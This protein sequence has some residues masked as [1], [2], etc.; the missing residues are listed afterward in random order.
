MLGLKLIHFS[1]SGHCSVD[2]SGAETWMFGANNIATMSSDSII[3]FRSI[4]FIMTKV[5]QWK[6]SNN[7]AWIQRHVPRMLIVL[8]AHQQPCRWLCK[9]DESLSS[10]QNDLYYLGRQKV[11]DASKCKYICS[12]KAIHHLKDCYRGIHPLKPVST[13]KTAIVAMF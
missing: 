11:K 4:M 12:F 10:T 13:Y 7:M 6:R 5:G 8:F 9:R 3:G 2:P 1:K